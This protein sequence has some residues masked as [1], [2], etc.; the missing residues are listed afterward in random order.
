MPFLHW[1]K[2]R[3]RLKQLC[4]IRC[5][6]LLVYV[7]FNMTDNRFRK[8]SVYNIVMFYMYIKAKVK[9]STA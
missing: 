5:L 8:T 2:R 7:V 6:L 9:S 1:L 4:C 3:I